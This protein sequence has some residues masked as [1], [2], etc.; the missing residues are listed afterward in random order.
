[1]AYTHDFIRRVLKVQKDKK[2]SHRAT[3]SLFQIGT[4][5]LSNWQKGLL[6]QGKRK[7]KPSKISDEALLNDVK[8]YPDA[9]H[10][11][12]AKRL[13]VSERGI[14]HA[15]HRLGITRKKRHCLT[16]KEMKKNG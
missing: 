4:T 15:L 5:T 16:Q 9:F 6:P 1:M 2:L 11:E 8:A 14:G 10:Y 3:A 13:N 12:R 7:R